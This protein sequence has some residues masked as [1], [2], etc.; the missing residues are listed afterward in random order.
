MDS[1]LLIIAIVVSTLSLGVCVVL[2]VTVLKSKKAA[3]APQENPETIAIINANLQSLHNDVNNLQGKVEAV[4]SN[5]PLVV[6]GQLTEKMV[7]IQKQLGEQ[8][9]K[10]SASM[11]SFQ[12]AINETLANNTSLSNKALQDSITAINK[13]VDDNFVTINQ[14]VNDSLTSGFKTTSD[15]MGELKKQL[16][17]IDNAQKR[18]EEVNS[19]IVS[20]NTLLSGN[21]TRGSF[22]ELQLEMLL[23]A[24]F[25]NGKGKYYNIQDDLGIVRDGEKVRPD[26]DIVFTSG[27]LTRK[28]C[29]DS[30]FPFADYS[31]LFSKEK[32]SVDEETALKTS[33][34]NAVRIKYKDIAAKYII[35]D[36]TVNYA[37]MFVPNDGVFAFIE[38]EFPDLVSEARNL[39][40]II[41][42]PATL[43]AIIVVF[44]NAATEAERNKNLEAITSALQKLSVEFGNLSSRWDTLQKTIDATVKKTHDFDVTVGKIGKQFDKIASND[45]AELAAPDEEAEETALPPEPSEK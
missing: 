21:Q 25:P 17:A 8:S 28:L 19:G 6:S 33:F 1:T 36:K 2:L 43:Q 14:R 20:L 7:A 27:D 23:E 3:A 22:G 41:A 37:V 39:K 16:G 11:A 29:I 5:L 26:A 9:E 15:T 24:T 4:Q 35:A 44:H 34:K 10:N 42:C 40:V 38:D 32:L 18:L 13:K 12:K 30:K 31:R 45:V